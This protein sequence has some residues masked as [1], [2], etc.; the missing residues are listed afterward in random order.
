MRLLQWILLPVLAAMAMSGRSG[1]EN[2]AKPDRFFSKGNSS[3]NFT[4]STKDLGKKVFYASCSICHKDSTLTVLAP[5]FTVLTSMPPRSIWAALESGK[6]RQQGANLSENE[7]R[8]VAQWLTNGS[9]TVNGFA[10]EAY[11]SFSI[12]KKTSSDHSGWGNNLEGTGFRT[13]SQS[14]LTTENVSSLQLK[15]AFA[16]PD[17]SV[18]RSKPAVVGNWLIVGGQYGEVLSL[19]KQTGK[20][21]WL[22]NASAAVRGGIVVKSEG[23]ALTAY[24]ADYVTN[25][26][27][28]D[29]K[30][31]KQLWSKRAGH[32]QMATVTGTV[33]VYNG[34]VYVPI[35]S[36]EAASTVNGNYPCCTSSGGVAALDARTGNEIWYHRVVAEPAHE[37]TKKRNGKFFYGPS[38][39]PVWCSPTVDSSRGLLYI[40]SGENYSLPTTNTSDAIQALDLKTGKLIWNFQATTN[41]AYNLACPVLVNCP[42]IPSPDLDFGMAPILVKRKGKKDILVAGQ[43]AGVVYALSPDNGKMLWHTRIGKGGALGGVH[44]GMAT[45][46]KYVYAANADNIIAIDKRDTSV[47]AAPGIFALDLN[48]GKV[49][50][51]VPSPDC[52]GKGC[53]VANSAA[54]LVIPGIVFAG[55]IDGHMRAYSSADGKILWDFNTVKEYETVN[56]IKGK[57]GSIDGP[58]P[59]ASDGMLFVNSGYGMFGQASG[60]VLLA[61][62]VKRKKN[63]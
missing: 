5:S 40:G 27:A 2:M 33:A 43:K 3:A 14:G 18:I 31:G 17:A 35:S 7:K 36:L 46:G 53:W 49:V 56:G 63:K 19:N 62:E 25:V 6:M 12:P 58:A 24:F 11:T 39:A 41:D 50:W 44:W 34:K 38:G 28:V 13:A 20:I 21:G 55:T 1:R 60:N 61:F 9:L 30:S 42:Q 4:D 52:E 32:D 8:A 23:N 45:D 51:K 54:P 29:V 26:Y 57:G 10:K 48:T 15:W 59:V 22:F 47:K 16:F 37:S